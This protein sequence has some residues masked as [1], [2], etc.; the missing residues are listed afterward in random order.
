MKIS[1]V[2][3]CKTAFQSPIEYNDADFKY[4]I[5][6]LNGCDHVESVPETSKI[7]EFG[8]YAKYTSV[9][10]IPIVSSGDVDDEAL[11]RSC[12]TVHSMLADR[13]D[14]RLAFSRTFDAQVVVLGKE[15]VFTEVPEYNHL[16]N[17]LVVL[18]IIGPG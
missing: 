15:E 13:N 6:P 2:L 8:F 1:P 12:R 5:N 3:L 17:R 11:K 10:G 16:K 18:Q 14:I 7:I 9:Y 4:E